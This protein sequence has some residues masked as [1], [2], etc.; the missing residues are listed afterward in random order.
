MHIPLP[1]QPEAVRAYSS[2]EVIAGVRAEAISYG[3]GQLNGS[4]RLIDATVE[5]TEPTGA[6]TL[7]VLT[8]GGQEFTA[9]L[10]PDFPL[11][12][13]DRGEFDIDLSKLV[14][15]DPQTEQRIE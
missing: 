12:P 4:R 2:K 1:P 15:F 14:F 6:D 9:R 7:A 11:R 10:Q 5:V 3:G 8:L 13:G